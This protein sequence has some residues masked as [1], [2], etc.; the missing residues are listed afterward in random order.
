ISTLVPHDR[1]VDKH[2]LVSDPKLFT[3]PV[4]VKGIWLDRAYDMQRREL[5]AIR[6]TKNLRV[7]MGRDQWQRAL[8]M[9]DVGGSGVGNGLSGALTAVTE[10]TAT[11]AG[12]G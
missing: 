12:G 1:K 8:M 3:D 4:K 9:G 11:S 10:T 7:T 2:L 6:R 5:T